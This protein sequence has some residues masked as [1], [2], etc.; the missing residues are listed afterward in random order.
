M[1]VASSNTLEKSQRLKG[2]MCRP[3]YDSAIPATSSTPETA[4]T[5]PAAQ[6]RILTVIRAPRASSTA[7]RPASAT[8]ATTLPGASL[9]S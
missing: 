9:T 8:H 5:Q 7:G 3:T 4:A 2:P 6:R 1:N